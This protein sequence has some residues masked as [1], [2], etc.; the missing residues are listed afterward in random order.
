MNF[1]F[2]CLYYSFC[3][4]SAR[5][6]S[7]LLVTQLFRYNDDSSSHRE[8]DAI[9][10]EV[11]KLSVQ[12]ASHAC[13]RFALRAE[14]TVQTS[15]NPP[16]YLHLLFP[17]NPPPVIPAP[18]PIHSHVHASL[19]YASSPNASVQNKKPL[20]S[21]HPLSF[22]TP[23]ILTPNFRC[24]WYTPCERRA[25]AETQIFNQTRRLAVQHQSSS[26]GVLGL[27]G[28]AGML[29]T[30]RPSDLRC[31]VGDRGWTGLLRLLLMKLRGVTRCTSRGDTG[32]TGSF[33]SRSCGKAVTN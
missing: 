4:E 20:L 1:Y 8:G 24:Q 9:R 21:S 33:A 13:V 6:I 10:R 19:L 12:Y 30:G 27:R 25:K 22:S 28:G 2:L 11:V 15:P 16:I 23:I 29:V 26:S 32:E 3:S 7:A 17:T 18:P 14:A 31:D 5:F